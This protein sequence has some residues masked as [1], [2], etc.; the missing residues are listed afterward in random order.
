M[1]AIPLPT[2]A[3]VQELLGALFDAFKVKPG[4]KF[5]VSAGAMAY[6]GLYVGDDGAA[7]ALCVCDMAFAVGVGAAL[8]MLPPN[9][10]KE[11]LQARNLSAVMADN[12]REV[13]NICAR[14]VLREGSPHLR[15]QDVCAVGALPPSAAAL[16]A[17]G[18]ARADFDV[19][20]GKYGGGK[21]AV[22]A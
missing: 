6:A 8:S 18:R 19:E 3:Q 22:F 10:M 16:M 21:L 12:L 14:L 2:A 9:S 1:T 5:D 17:A 15:L 20:L 11:A 4:A 7:A 13:M